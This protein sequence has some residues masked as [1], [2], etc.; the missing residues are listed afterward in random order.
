M[1]LSESGD[2]AMPL[3]IKDGPQHDGKVFLSFHIDLAIR[4]TVLGQNI[5]FFS[6]LGLTL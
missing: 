5:E 2:D 4:I 1:M 6:Q 3:L